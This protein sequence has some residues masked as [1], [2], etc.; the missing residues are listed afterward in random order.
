MAH[1]SRP[2]RVAGIALAAAAIAAGAVF[3]SLYQDRSQQGEFA[4]DPRP[5]S[6]VSAGTAARLLSEPTD[7]VEAMSYCS[8]AG[9]G[10]GKDAQ[11]VLQVQVTRLRLD[12]ARSSFQ[13]TQEEAAVGKMG[14]MTTDLTDF[15]DE[16]FVRTRHPGGGRG[17][18]EIFFRRSNVVVAVRYAPVDG[19]GEKAYAGAYD[20]ATEAAA[21]LRKAR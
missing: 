18:T 4:S 10:L 11:P 20:A 5:C 17:T 19:D 12:E 1:L 16:A 21:E 15:G 13:R 9:P 2:A 3:A 14:P 8:W 6:L 7:G